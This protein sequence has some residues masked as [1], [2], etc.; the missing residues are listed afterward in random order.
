MTAKKFLVVFTAAYVVVLTLVPSSS[1]AGD[2]RY[3]HTHRSDGVLRAG[4]HRYHFHYTLHPDRVFKGK[5]NGKSWG[6]EFFLRDP[7]GRG[8]GSAV[9]EYQVDPRRGPALFKFCRY[10]TQ[11]GRFTIR[12]RLTVKHTTCS[13]P[14]ATPATCETHQRSVWIGRSHFRLRRH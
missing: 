12:G 1:V 4:C 6:A 10:S 8:L 5:G 3:G 2:V 13:T 7:K 11:P 14:I 9:K